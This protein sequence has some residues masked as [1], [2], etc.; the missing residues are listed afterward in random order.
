MAIKVNRLTNANIYV[1]G[2]NMLGRAAEIELPE[3]THKMSDHE[4][5]GMI[6]MVEFFSGIEKMEGK[7][8]WNAFYTDALGFI[9]DPTKTVQLMVRS[10]LETYESAGR[11]DEVAVVVYL[12]VQFKSLPLGNY[13][14]HE[15]V[16]LESQFAC[17]ASKMEIDGAPQ[18]EIDLLSNI[19]KVQGVDIM[20]NYRANIGA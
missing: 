16:E 3:I 6:G 2:T 17:Y 4:A 8:K 14:Q 19:Y 11:T 15:N 5:L 20:A 18:V 1:D 9:G 12:T 10:S 7:I 13:Q